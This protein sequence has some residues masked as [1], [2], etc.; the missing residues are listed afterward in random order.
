MEL[1]E[2]EASL[3]GRVVLV[4]EERRLLDESCKELDDRESPLAE[5]ERESLS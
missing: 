4:N 5:T 2:Q 3:A 1:A